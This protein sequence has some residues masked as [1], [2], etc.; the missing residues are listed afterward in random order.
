MSSAWAAVRFEDGTVRFCV[1]SG[2]S[3]ILLPT[4]YDSI[5]AAWAARRDESWVECPCAE[6]EPV[7]VW[8]TYG[9]GFGWPARACR[10]R[11]LHEHCEPWGSESQSGEVI[12]PAQEQFRTEPDWVPA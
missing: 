3:D 8:V 5:E 12:H 4:L 2:T 10:H 6:I 7:T 9:G 11:V 1:Y